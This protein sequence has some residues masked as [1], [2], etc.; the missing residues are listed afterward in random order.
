MRALQVTTMAQ[1]IGYTVALAFAT[2][3]VSGAQAQQ[4]AAAG[5][6]GKAAAKPAVKA[7]AAKPAKKAVVPGP[8]I[9]LE[10]KAMAIIK[11]A[12]NKLAAAKTLSFTAVVSEESP[13]RLGPALLYNSR[14][15]VV[16]QRP[17][18][19]RIVSP[20]DGPPSEFYSDGKSMVA[21][22]P[23]EN[24]IAIA[25]A[26]SD[27]DAVLDAAYSKASIYFPFVDLIVA[28][29][30]KDLSEGLRVAFYIGQSQTVGGTTTD[31][32]AW[33]NDHAFVQ[34]WVGTE[35]KLPRKLRAVFRKDAKQLRHEM[36]ISNWQIDG[37]VAAEAFGPPP[38]AKSA[39]PIDFSRPDAAPP[40][41]SRMPVK[42]TAKAA[43]Q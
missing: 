27:I 35:D 34:A 13:S 26:P 16:L 30:Y 20:G 12:A 9:E 11:A 39:L 41:G 8:A 23:K 43:T 25:P 4:P 31:I 40:P 3:L 21:F 14:Y 22:A 32:V 1:G 37:P 38:S 6:A 29:P 10:P 42:G 33:A 7:S 17:D 15:D 2:M 36:E 18:K 28:D 24:L 5:D 19:L